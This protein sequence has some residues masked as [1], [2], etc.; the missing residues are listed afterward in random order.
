MSCAAIQARRESRA[1]AAKL[2]QAAE[3]ARERKRPEPGGQAIK[4]SEGLSSW[5]GRGPRR[6]EE[7]LRAFHTWLQGAV[8]KAEAGFKFFI[9]VLARGGIEGTQSIT[10]F[11]NP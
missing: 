7:A 2:E 8:R 9:C 10:G 6:K 1:A 3:K 11:Y 4:T 5:A